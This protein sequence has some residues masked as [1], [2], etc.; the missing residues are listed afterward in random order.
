MKKSLILLGVVA[1]LA[2]PASAEWKK[3]DG[4]K[5]PEITSSEWLNTGKQAPTAASLRGKVWLLEF[6]ATW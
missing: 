6:F 3:L 5:V 1:G 4:Q 2:L